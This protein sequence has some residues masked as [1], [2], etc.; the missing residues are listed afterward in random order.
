MFLLDGHFV[1]KNSKKESH[2]FKHS[3]AGNRTVRTLK[4]EHRLDIHSIFEHNPKRKKKTF[5]KKNDLLNLYSLDFMFA[6]S[7][8]VFDTVKRKVLLP[9]FKCSHRLCGHTFV[10]VNSF[11]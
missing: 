8:P 11:Q 4:N 7:K 9:F 5:Q 2:L 10:F 3:S 6:S 1:S